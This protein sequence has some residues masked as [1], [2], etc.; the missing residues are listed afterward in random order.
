MEENI[1]ARPGIRPSIAERE[2]Q[3]YSDELGIRHHAERLEASLGT[4]RALQV[5]EEVTRTIAA[6]RPPAPL[7]FV[8]ALRK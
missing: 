2:L 5:L 4:D 8:K 7:V 3:A 1:M 6:R